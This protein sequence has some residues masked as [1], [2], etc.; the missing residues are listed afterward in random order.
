MGRNPEIFWVPSR[1]PDKFPSSGSKPKKIS[2]FWVGTQKKI[3]SSELRKFPDYFRFFFA[4]FGTRKNREFFRR[5][6]GRNPEL[7]ISVETLFCFTR[8]F[9]VILC[10]I[11]PFRAVSCS[12]V[13]LRGCCVP[14]SALCNAE[15]VSSRSVP[16]RASLRT[17]CPVLWRA[18]PRQGRSCRPMT[19]YAVLR[20]FFAVQ[21][22]VVPPW[23]RFVLF[24]AV[25][26]LVETA[27][28]TCIIGGL[29]GRVPFPENNSV[30][31]FATNIRYL[32]SNL[33]KLILTK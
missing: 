27:M 8:L 13:L 9:R 15:A 31:E 12:A 7:R 11:V 29:T 16:C 25:P 28:F 14:F 24:C 17:F 20:S 23:G 18:M 33:F 26:C 2:E 30:F 22:R 19:Y 3:S 4:W 6:P 32:V 1:N 10:R 21:C 5:F